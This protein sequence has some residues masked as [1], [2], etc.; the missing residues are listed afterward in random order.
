[1]K[2]LLFAAFALSLILVVSAECN[3]SDVT[4]CSQDYANMVSK[5]HVY[6]YN[7]IRVC[8]YQCN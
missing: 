1:M 5:L 2:S 7:C 3:V 6:P 8:G 4:T